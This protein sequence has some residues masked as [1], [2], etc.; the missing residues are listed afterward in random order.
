M[1]AKVS[2]DDKNRLRDILVI[3]REV[4]DYTVESDFSAASGGAEI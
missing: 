4:I 3:I 2:G 1:Q